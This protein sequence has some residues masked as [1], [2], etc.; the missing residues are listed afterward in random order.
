MSDKPLKG[1][2]LAGG[3]GNRLSPLTRVAGKHFLPVYNRPMVLHALDALSVAGVRDALVVTD[4]PGEAIARDLMAD[5]SEFGLDSIEMLVQKEPTGIAAGLAL[6]EPF[7]GDDD[8]LA[9]LGDN[10][11]GRPLT[12]AVEE[13]RRA[14]REE[15]AEGLVTVCRV[16]NPTD[17]GIASFD[18]SAARLVEIIEKPAEPPTDLAVTGA[19]LYRPAVF[20]LIAKMEPDEHGIL[21]ITALNNSLLARGTLE[22]IDLDGWWT[23]A[24]TFEGLRKATNLVAEHGINGRLPAHPKAD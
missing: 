10:L 7:A 13:F 15:G 11:F 8:L 21:E 4:P 6:A 1:V 23:D 18:G 19:Y 2:V 12:P 20:G 9:L 24:G 22:W 5:P 17:Y 16:E 3:R 14:V